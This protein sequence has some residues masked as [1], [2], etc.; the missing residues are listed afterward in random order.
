MGNYC[1][2]CMSVPNWNCI[3]NKRGNCMTVIARV[4]SVLER[5]GKCSKLQGISNVLQFLQRY[6]NKYSIS[7]LFRGSKA[8]PTD[9][10]RPLLEGCRA[11]V[12]EPSGS[13]RCRFGLTY[14]TTT[15]QSRWL[16]FLR[17][18]LS[19]TSLQ[20][21]TPNKPKT[22]LFHGEIVKNRSVDHVFVFDH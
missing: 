21:T 4:T 3:S 9:T 16:H 14:F 13:P 2:E 10:K 12:S 7:L 6:W 15:L 20:N 8:G 22:S 18:N 5:F 17:V 19:N 1:H 11:G